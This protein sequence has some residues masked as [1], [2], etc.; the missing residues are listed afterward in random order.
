MLVS[1]SPMFCTITGAA[2]TTGYCLPHN[3]VSL[4]YAS[5]NAGVEQEPIKKLLV[6][7]RGWYTFT[8]IH[9]SCKLMELVVR[10]L[11]FLDEFSRRLRTG[12][13]LTFPKPGNATC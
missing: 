6:A 12:L 3:L 13:L 9:C 7:N 2:V 10:D 11:Y 8:H 4:R 1:V 5:Q